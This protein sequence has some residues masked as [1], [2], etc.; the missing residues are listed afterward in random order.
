MFEIEQECVQVY[1]RKVDEAAT[2]RSE[3]QQA[4][5]VAEME[6]E[7]ICS[8]LGEQPVKVSEITLFKRIYRL[9]NFFVLFFLL[10]LCLQHEQIKIGLNLKEE[11]QAIIPRLEEMRKR[12]A[13]RKK[14]FVEVVEDL[15]D[16]AKEI[17]GSADDNLCKMA[18]DGADLSMKKLE[19]LQ[20][21]LQEL[22]NEKVYYP[23]LTFSQITFLSNLEI[24]A[25]MLGKCRRVENK[26]ILNSIWDYLLFGMINQRKFNYSPC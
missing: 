24:D 17:F 6:I 12:R 22:Q 14:Q 3:L 7:S 4:I 10:V 16:I 9:S 8:E 21:R 19:E 20:K 26:G 23:L 11:L 15:Q 25:A 5:A 2:C 18:V 13:E 1:R